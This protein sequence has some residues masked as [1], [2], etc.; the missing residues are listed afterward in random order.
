MTVTV[1]CLRSVTPDKL[2]LTSWLMFEQTNVHAN[3]LQ[4]LEKSSKL[5]IIVDNTRQIY[6]FIQRNC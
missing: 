1:S 5:F 6:S 3:T 2:L 4:N